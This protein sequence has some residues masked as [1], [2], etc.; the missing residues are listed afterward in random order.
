MMEKELSDDA[1]FGLLGKDQGHREEDQ[2]L[3]EKK[4]RW[5]RAQQFQMKN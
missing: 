5:G 2:L 1:V 4:E 3:E